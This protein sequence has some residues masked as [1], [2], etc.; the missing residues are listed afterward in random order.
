LKL[1]ATNGGNHI[2]L[3]RDAQR[4]DQVALPTV[5]Q[6]PS[7][8][9][10]TLYVE[11][12]APSAN[13]RDVELTLEYDEVPEGTPQDKQYLFKCSDKIKL[14]VVKVDLDVDSEDHWGSDYLTEEF[15]TDYSDGIEDKIGKGK[16]KTI[17]VN[18]LDKDADGVV[19][20]VDGW[21]CPVSQ[22]QQLERE[23][24]GGRNLNADEHFVPLVLEVGIPQSLVDKSVLKVDY[25]ESRP[26]SMVL[27]NIPVEVGFDDQTRTITHQK[28]VSHEGSIRIW[29][30]NG[31]HERSVA[32]DYVES[33]KVY[34][35]S[36]LTGNNGICTLYIEGINASSTWS[37]I[38]IT[39][40]LSFDEG[41]KW[42]VSD[43][44]R[45]TCVKSNFQI[46]NVRPYYIS[47]ILGTRKIY[48][49]DY[50]TP[51]SC[52]AKM[53]QC[54]HDTQK[55]FAMHSGY[56]YWWHEGDAVLGHGFA[57]FEYD[58]PNLGDALYSSC[59]A[60]EFDHKF[61][62]GKTGWSGF[63][64]WEYG[65]GETNAQR[66]LAW[67]DVCNYKVESKWLV[68]KKKY[69]MQPEKLSRLFATFNDY[70]DRYCKF[71]LH[72]ERP[73]KGWGCLSNVG[74]AMVENDVDTAKIGLCLFQKN[75]PNTANR[76]VWNII[77]G[78]MF[79]NNHKGKAGLEVIDN[80]V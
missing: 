70:P 63:S 9:P 71:G 58:G 37:D 15:R 54:N 12:V 27:E 5:W 76:S 6:N 59:S 11:G 79:G 74:L 77:M 25:P 14:T 60:S 56:D 20:Y 13:V 68:L 38:R 66:E 62:W 67:W 75:M 33:G 46:C 65:V 16:G 42:V 52:I 36:E 10:T 4:S 47:D 53:Y 7:Q 40:S 23:K 8:M 44:V 45:C 72:I 41:M 78:T 57:C 26:Q 51:A 69:A 39:A 31:S 50:S 80:V 35:T 48:T 18:N 19:D 1:S 43:A 32:T 29:S 55:Y 28:I 21:N 22:I 24:Q 30:K 2:R 34:R 73:T 64:F 3:W 17:F 49:P 61:F